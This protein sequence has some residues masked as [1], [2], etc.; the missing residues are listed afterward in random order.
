MASES[1]DKRPA[2]FLRR[3]FVVSFLLGAALIGGFGIAIVCFV[4]GV[5]DCR[6]GQSQMVRGINADDHPNW[7]VIATGA[8]FAIGLF[9]LVISSIRFHGGL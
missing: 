1:S 6:S 4:A 3:W 9:F 5:M 7:W 2:N 8:W